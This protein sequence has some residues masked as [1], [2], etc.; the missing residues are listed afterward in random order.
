[1]SSE[2]EAEYKT[3]ISLNLAKEEAFLN[4]GIV[5]FNDKKYEKA[6]S[7]WDSTVAINPKNAD[8]YNNL[9]ASYL[10]FKQDSK[11]A[12]PYFEKAVELSPDFTQGY[13][14]I[15]VCAQNSNDEQATI[16]YTRILLDK[17]TS[18]ND[19]KAKGINYSDALLKK[20]NA[21]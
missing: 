13:I 6:I 21:R 12:M 18:I 17:G 10:N 20:I 5:Y 19:I 16:K 4:L 7:A 8:A 2:A 14:N 3:E 1:M 15:L 9:G 11:K